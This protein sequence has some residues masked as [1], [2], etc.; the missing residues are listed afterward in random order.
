MCGEGGVVD[1]PEMATE[2]GG[3]HPTGTPSCKNIKL[4][5]LSNYRPPTKF[6]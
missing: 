3:T 1:T 4:K 6:W 2:E 5:L